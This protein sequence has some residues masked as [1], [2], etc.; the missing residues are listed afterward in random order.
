MYQDP[1]LSWWKK[2]GQDWE[3]LV[4]NNNKKKT[5]ANRLL[6]VSDT[7]RRCT[8]IRYKEIFWCLIATAWEVGV[9]ILYVWVYTYLGLALHNSCLEV[10]P[11][12]ELPVGSSLAHQS[13]LLSIYFPDLGSGV[14]NILLNWKYNKK[15][16][17]PLVCVVSPDRSC[18]EHRSQ[19]QEP[20]NL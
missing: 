17:M 11:R 5:S 6:Q 9:H 15:L 12:V 18:T 13:Q 1:N 7:L 19:N 3:S 14:V 8:Y 2:G 20:R 16:C 10:T 4:L